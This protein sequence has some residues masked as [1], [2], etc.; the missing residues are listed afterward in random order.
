MPESKLFFAGSNDFAVD[1]VA[2]AVRALRPKSRFR[3]ASDPQI[4]AAL[5]DVSAQRIQQT[6][7]KLV[8][9]QTRHTLSSDVP[10]SPARD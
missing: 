3:A 8:S 9:F 5:R 2:A 10:A 1:I 6:I 7:E 4:A